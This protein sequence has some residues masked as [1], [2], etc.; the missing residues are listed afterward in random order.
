[1]TKQEI[2]RGTR[3]AVKN[4][5]DVE[6]SNAVE[7]LIEYG[8]ISWRHRTAIQDGIYKARQLA[9]HE[10]EKRPESPCEAT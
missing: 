4:G 6:I 2:E 3:K 10:D 7:W 1:M 8:L 5:V 9:K